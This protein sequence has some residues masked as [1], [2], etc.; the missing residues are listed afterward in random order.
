MYRRNLL[1]NSK[2]RKCPCLVCIYIYENNMQIARDCRTL[3]E[4]LLF[5]DFLNGSCGEKKYT[6]KLSLRCMEGTFSKTQRQEKVLVLFAFI[7]MK[8]CSIAIKP[9]LRGIGV[10]SFLFF[11]I[12]LKIS[13]NFF[14]SFVYTG[15]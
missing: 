10:L 14:A 9:W 7:H 5:N 3:D 11:L 4:V 13:S 1:K 2:T 6:L 8:Y 15:L 12:F